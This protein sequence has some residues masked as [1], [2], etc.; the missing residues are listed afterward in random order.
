MKTFVDAQIRHALSNVKPRRVGRAINPLVTCAVIAFVGFLASIACAVPSFAQIAGTVQLNI[1][2]R[3]HTATLLEDGKVLIVGGDNQSGIVNQVELLDPASQ[4]SSLAAMPIVARTDHS[5]TI[6]ADG[7]V[8][9]IGGRDQNGSLTSTEIYN[10]LTATFTAGPALTTTRSGHTSTVLA[11]GNILV[12]GGDASGSAELYNPTTQS[13]SLIAG[14]MNTARKFQSAILL[15]NG[16]VLIAGGVG[17]ENNVLNTAEVY[18]PSSQSFYVP[19]TDMQTPRALGI[20]KLLSDGKVQIIG[21]DAELSMEVFD[22]T[23]GIF[24]AKALLPPNADLLGATLSTQS[25]AALF[26]P[27]ISQDPLLQGVLTPE[28]LAL[29]D[30]ADH[31]ITELPSR[32][33]ALVAG[34][35]NSAGQTFNSATLVSSSTA[36]VTTDKTDYAP[37]EI[38]TIIGGGFQPNE[39][40]Q[41]SLHEFPEA[42]PDIT[43]T[44]VANQQGNFV[45]TDFAPQLIDLDRIFTL[46]AIGQS[47]GFTAQTAFK[48]A[49]KT[50]STSVSC[51]PSSVGIGSSS[52][53]TATVTNT[54][55][56][57]NTPDGTVNFTSSGSGTFTAPSS[58]TLPS[59]PGNNLASCSVAYTPSSGAGTHTITGTYVPAN[60]ANFSGSA[61]GFGLTVTATGTAPTITSSNNTTFTV[62]TAGSFTVTTTGSPTPAI[63]KTGTLPT[64]ITFIDNS[65]GTATLSGTPAL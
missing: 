31:S 25:R 21:G 57:N 10:L 6:L 4:T 48:D 16:Q 3:G 12:A 49:A 64:G 29:L 1:E 59:N 60:T 63:T 11:N 33:Q 43:F 30:R 34:G 17:A 58:C 50:T 53:C 37:G 27:T 20:L 2:R 65:N 19:P 47:S 38:V 40:V 28:Q 44:A 35:I 55:T 62:G 9:I 22:P 13:F 45:A 41:L 56:G 26:S 14:S 42:Y 32:N 51:S 8:L 36:S 46:T 5:A 52:T 7:R 23:N 39:Q 18:D 54:G 61:G 15:N 24:I